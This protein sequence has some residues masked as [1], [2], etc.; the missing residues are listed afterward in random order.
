[1]NQHN[2]KIKTVPYAQ[3]IK[4]DAKISYTGRYE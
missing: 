4:K 1:M 3:F 2:E